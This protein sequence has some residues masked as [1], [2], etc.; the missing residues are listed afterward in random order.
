M[1]ELLRRYALAFL[2]VRALIDLTL[3]VMIYRQAGS[4]VPA[5]ALVLVCS[6]FYIILCRGIMNEEFP[7]RYGRRVILWREPA[8][9][10]LVVGF[11][12]A[13]HLAVTALMA[14][15]VRR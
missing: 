14:W 11:L 2:A 1:H 6:V 10:W 13:S 5:V 4:L 9:Y 8:G 15:A 12:V 3:G 7:G